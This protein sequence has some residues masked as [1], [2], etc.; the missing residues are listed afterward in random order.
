VVLCVPRIG[1]GESNGAK[2]APAKLALALVRPD[3][4]TI[5]KR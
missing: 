4:E 5:A 1:E 2:F 3:R